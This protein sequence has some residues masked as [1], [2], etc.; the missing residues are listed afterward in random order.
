MAAKT[1]STTTALVTVGLDGRLCER[2]ELRR[3]I[4]PQVPRPWTLLMLS[5]EC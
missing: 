3:Q 5:L 2:A 4:R 1:T